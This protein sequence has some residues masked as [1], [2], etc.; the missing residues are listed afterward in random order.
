ML[1]VL[2]SEGNCFQLY[3]STHDYK[4]YFIEQEAFLAIVNI[5]AF[6]S[7]LLD[8]M[9][10]KRAYDKEV[11][12]LKG[13]PKSKINK[14][15]TKSFLERVADLLMA[16]S[17]EVPE[18]SK[19]TTIPRI[20]EV[21]IMGSLTAFINNMANDI[22]I[23]SEYPIKKGDNNRMYYA[24]FFLEKDDEKLI[25]EV[26]NVVHNIARILS[27]GTNQL[28]TYLTASRVKQGILYIPPTRKEVELELVTLEKKVGED[29][30]NIVQIYPK[31][32]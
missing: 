11:N 24:D 10:E 8:Q 26:K 18:K 22:N 1:Q 27:I 25:I 6:I 20:T 28:M 7:I 13:K 32:T 31:K 16:Y 9:V 19:G 5:S 15:K 17:V 30:Y 3:K 12:D 2:C 23:F 14:S 21:E 4:L 29:V